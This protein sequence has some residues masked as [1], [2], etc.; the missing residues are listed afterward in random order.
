MVAGDFGLQTGLLV[1]R[2]VRQLVK[3]RSSMLALAAVLLLAV[4][5]L[6]SQPALDQSPVVHGPFASLL[7][8]STD[9]GPARTDQVQLTVALTDTRRPAA[10]VAWASDNDLSV[11]WRPGDNWAIVEG[12][13]ADVAETFRVS[14]RDYRGRRGQV[15]YASPQQPSVPEPLRREVSGVGRILGYT[16]HHMARPVIAMT[17]TSQPG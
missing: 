4:S 14:V 6:P 9:L 13:P 12:T 1:F 3:P 7:A 15:F 5:D 17:E 16:P 11:R 10:L 8:G 2:A